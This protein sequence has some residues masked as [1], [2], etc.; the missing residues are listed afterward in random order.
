[1]VA[2]GAGPHLRSRMR[3]DAAKCNRKR[4]ARPVGLN[5]HNYSF[6]ALDQGA[7]WEAFRVRCELLGRNLHCM[8]V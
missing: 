3:A 2:V 8:L 6:Q 5:V 1:M 4:S 7:I